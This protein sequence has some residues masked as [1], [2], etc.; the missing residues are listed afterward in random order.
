MC[1]WCTVEKPRH[2]FQTYRSMTNLSPLFQTFL[3]VLYVSQLDLP[4]SAACAHMWTEIRILFFTSE[5]HVGRITLLPH[6]FERGCSLQIVTK[7]LTSSTLYHIFILIYIYIYPYIGL[8]IYFFMLKACTFC[9]VTPGT[10]LWP[11]S[12]F[13]CSVEKRL[14]HSWCP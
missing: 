9:I 7:F 2:T 5:A 10:L 3:L 13:R 6:C 11:T 12:S 8:F 14:P 1:I 4:S